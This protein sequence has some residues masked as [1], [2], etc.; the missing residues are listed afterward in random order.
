MTV[1]A[2]SVNA[3][4]EQYTLNPWCGQPPAAAPRSC[5]P[6]FFI[7]DEPSLDPYG[8]GRPARGEQRC[9]PWV[10]ATPAGAPDCGSPSSRSLWTPR[11]CFCTPR[12]Y[13]IHIIQIENSPSGGPGLS[14]WGLRVQVAWA[15]VLPPHC[16]RPRAVRAA[17]LDG[18]RRE[19]GEGR[20]VRCLGPWEMESFRHCS[21]HGISD[22]AYEIIIVC[23][24]A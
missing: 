8:L 15:G 18:P 17:G 21:V 19:L 12:I 23:G 9:G 7:R 24:G 13:F 5:S 4:Y 3:G 14:F 11:H 10:G 20:A 2:M 16:R 22:S 1:L 6:L